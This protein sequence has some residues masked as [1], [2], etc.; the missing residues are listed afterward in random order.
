[1]AEQKED[2]LHT[3]R[4]RKQFEEL[5]L[6]GKGGFGTVMKV[7]DRLE[8]TLYAVKKIR[9]HLKVCDD[10]RQELKS[11]KVFR[12]VS[13]LASSSSLELKHTVRYFNSWLEDLTTEE[14]QAEEAQLLKF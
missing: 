12:E 13:I 3:G 2:L 7:K 14:Q 1:M 4:Y 8:E 5:Q 10:L 9:L 11:H 6:L